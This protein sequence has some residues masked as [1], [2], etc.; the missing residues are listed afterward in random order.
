VE[1]QVSTF[2]RTLTDLVGNEFT[3]VVNGVSIASDLVEAVNLSPAVADQLSVD[4]CSNQFAVN[5]PEI[6]LEDFLTIRLCRPFQNAFLERLFLNGISCSFFSIASRVNLS[7]ISDFSL[8][9]V[10][11]LD[12]LLSNESVMFESE[13]DLLEQIFELGFLHYPLLGHL[14]PALLSQAGKSFFATAFPD[15]HL[16]ESLFRECR[17]LI[18]CHLNSTLKSAILSKCPLIFSGF[19]DLRFDLLWQRTRDGFGTIEFH[20]H[21]EAHRKTLTI[22][23]DTNDNIFG[24]FRLQEWV[25]DAR[26]SGPHSLAAAITSSMIESLALRADFLFTIENPLGIP[27]RIFKCRYDF[28]HADLLSINTRNR[29][30]FG[31]DLAIS[32]HCD[33][34]RHSF[35]SL[36]RSSENP[37]GVEGDLVSTGDKNFTVREIEVFELIDEESF[38]EAAPEFVSASDV[39]EDDPAWVGPSRVQN[40]PETTWGV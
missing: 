29:L 16:T 26:R 13:D 1:A 35:T 7:A 17:S 33:E 9:S 3:F 2:C 23:M 14:R 8:L 21:S 12:D 27:P 31:D 11:A 36:G 25:P 4:A 34:N 30:S 18:N 20:H 5:S 39:R 22:V 15:L 24:G 38:R 40:D 10:D 37:T 28:D 19:S 32:D 6:W